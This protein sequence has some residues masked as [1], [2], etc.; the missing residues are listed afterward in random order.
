MRNKQLCNK[1]KLI[2]HLIPYVTTLNVSFRFIEIGWLSFSKNIENSPP[3]P[4]SAENT[5][6][7]KVPCSTFKI[8]EQ[9]RSLIS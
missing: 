3:I 7:V 2:S 6:G 1:A 4:P 8:R 5:S 9:I